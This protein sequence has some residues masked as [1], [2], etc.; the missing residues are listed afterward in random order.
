MTT[1]SRARV[2][3]ASAAVLL[4]AALAAPAHGADADVVHDSE[5]IG[6]R[7]APAASPEVAERSSDLKIKKVNVRWKGKW[8]KRKMRA[9]TRVPKVGRL[10]L[11]CQPNNTMIKIV[12]DDRNAETQMWLAKYEKK[13][14]EDVV[15]VKNVRVYKYDTADDDG[16]GGTGK[17]AHEG[18]NQQ[19]PVETFS[20]GYA[21]GVI[22]TRPGRHLEIGDTGLSP[23][24]S[25]K[26]NWW[27]E[28]FREPRRFQ[29]CKMNA[30]LTTDMT[31][32]DQVVWHGE[33]DTA[34]RS[35]ERNVGV[36]GTLETRCEADGGDKQITLFTEPDADV[37]VY[38]KLIY[39]EGT[40]DYHVEEDTLYN[41]GTGM[42]G[43]IDLPG[44]GMLELS[45]SKDGSTKRNY[46]VSS[47]F[48]TND[49]K[50]PE[51]NLCEVAASRF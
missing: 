19:T 1:P 27:W 10:V 8:K 30:V 14:G 5:R 9:S 47:Y 42:V 37:S 24:T 41:D 13:N 48:I 3:V 4:T 18:L 6:S 17:Q 20:T 45:Y 31:Q 49:A 32:T 23:A 46:F 36:L 11:V 38:T 16:R 51:L 50:N 33:A 26:F 39:A 29:S 22:S 12:P 21:D 7:S 2:L 40:L 35:I 44:N 43:P 28:N 25:L 34:P 15:A